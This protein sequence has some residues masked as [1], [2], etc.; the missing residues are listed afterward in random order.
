MEEQRLEIKRAIIGTGEY[1]IKSKY[2]NLAI[3]HS[4][5]F[6]MSNDQ[7][8]RKISR[9]MKA[10]VENDSEC[11]RASDNP[12]DVLEL[13]S[14]VRK[15]MWEKAQ[16]LSMNETNIVQAPGDQS[17]YMVKSYSNKRPH[18]VKMSHR[19]GFL[20]N[21][22]C[23]SYKSMK[24][25]SHIVALAIKENCLNNLLKWYR[26]MKYTPNFTTLAE[27]GK[28][29]TAGKTSAKGYYKKEVRTNPKYNSTCRR[30][31]SRVHEEKNQKCNCHHPTRVSV[32]LQ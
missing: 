20:C 14:H 4:K 7:R 27:S 1:Q 30:G 15:S 29:S 28:P 3:E 26:T 11:S 23:L 18:Y 19:G 32:H 5:W 9:F 2:N 10:T 24:I 16:D 12:L 25:C 13:P 21:D 8:Q 31:K 17:A 22:Q 6:K